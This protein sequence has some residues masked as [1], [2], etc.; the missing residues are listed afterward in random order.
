LHYSPQVFA[1]YAALCQRHFL[2]ATKTLREHKKH[3]QEEDFKSYQKRVFR[4]IKFLVQ[5]LADEN[6]ET[7]KLLFQIIHKITT[8][9]VDK[10][11]RN[12]Q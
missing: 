12:Q 3:H 10:Y 1:S 5:N 2:R 7:L 6:T 4:D 8:P 11:E 9:I